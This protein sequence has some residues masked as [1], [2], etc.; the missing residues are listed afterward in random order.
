MSD[1]TRYAYAVA[2]IRGMETGLLTRQLVERLLAE[3]VG[4]ALSVLSDTSYQDALADVARP[5]DLEEGL[6]RALSDTL[7]TV[8]AIAPDP[9]LVGLFRERW[10]FRN[11]RSLLK[12]AALKLDREGSGIV[13]GPGLVELPVIEKAVRDK[14]YSVLPEHLAEAARDADQAYRDSNELSAIDGVID[15]ALWRR[16]LAVATERRN[17]FLVEYLRAEIDLQNI[18]T[19]VRIKTSR[20][21]RDELDRA[22]IGGGTLDLSTFAGFMEEPI[23]AFARALEYGRYGRVSEVLRD[24][25]QGRMPALELA[26]DDFLLRLTEGGT[27]TAYGVEPL[28][29]Y[30]LMRGLELKLV[31]MILTGKLDGVDRSELESRLRSLHA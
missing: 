8:A 10:D 1:D 11:L 26:A 3:P 25:S 27:T 7:A 19:F 15:A 21:E 22:F 6:T 12:A 9:D 2:R 28:V 14:D 29:R 24:W 5:E 4:G 30:I 13:D 17:D 20:G 31:R 23:E 16:S 18:K